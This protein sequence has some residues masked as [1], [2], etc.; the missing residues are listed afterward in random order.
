VPE[1]GQLGA[2][3]WIT[4]RPVEIV[5]G[6]RRTE[7]S[8]PSAPGRVVEH[9]PRRRRRSTTR[10]HP[11]TPRPHRCP[12]SA[13]ADRRR[14]PAA[15]PHG[16]PASRPPARGAAAG[17]RLR[18]PQARQRPLPPGA[19]CCC[20][21]SPPNARTRAR[22]VPGLR[23]AQ[24]VHREQPRAQQAHAEP[25]SRS[26]P[27]GSD[28]ALRCAAASE[29]ASVQPPR[30][31]AHARPW[32]AW[33][34]AVHAGEALG[35][36]GESGCGKSTT[37]LAVLRMLEPTAGSIR[38]RGRPTS[39]ARRAASMRA[40]RRRMQMVYQ[41]PSAVAEPAH[42]RCAHRRRAAAGARHRPR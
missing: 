36:V 40:L 14:P 11:Y 1:R 6:L 25:R 21:R 18:P 8:R 41:D 13:S 31:R 7:V 10:Q 35:L 39:P 29:G 37:G 5:A 15:A 19:A 12:G 34:L 27:G 9:R 20:A 2:R 32:T 38:V 16:S 28:L 33:T 3:S 4:P 22:A 23:R 24:C 30:R 17:L 42:A 26:C